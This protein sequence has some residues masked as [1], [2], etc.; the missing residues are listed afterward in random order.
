VSRPVES[1]NQFAK[2]LLAAGDLNG[3]FN[4]LA[5]GDETDRAGRG[6][7]PIRKMYWLG[8]LS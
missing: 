7:H 3:G 4:G 5:R 1:P 2:I 8:F 6:E